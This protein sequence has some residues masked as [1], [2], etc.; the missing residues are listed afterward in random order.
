MA[1]RRVPQDGT[2]PADNSGESGYF[3]KCRRFEIMPR[4]V[5]SGKS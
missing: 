2:W 3:N 4:S 5:P 1:G